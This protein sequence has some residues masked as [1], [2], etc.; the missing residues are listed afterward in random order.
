VQQPASHA[1]LSISLSLNRADARLPATACNNET[2]SAFTAVAQARSSTCGDRLASRS[3][4]ED[5]M[6]KAYL[7]ALMVAGAIA[8]AAPGAL[9]QPNAPQVDVSTKVADADFD[10]SVD[11]G[12][13]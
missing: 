11:N 4:Q 9:A 1:S 8:S 3:V 2:A 7:S 5:G 12:A 13:T 10:A 6:S